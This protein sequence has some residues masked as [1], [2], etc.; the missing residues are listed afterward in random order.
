MLA[1]VPVDN[2]LL[3]FLVCLA[4]TRSGISDFGNWLVTILI[5]QG[6]ETRLY[7]RKECF[8]RLIYRGAFL[9]RRCR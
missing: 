6:A 4:E 7:E 8:I 2:A 9:T 1:R 3:H 5:G